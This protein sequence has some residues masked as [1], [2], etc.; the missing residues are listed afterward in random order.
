M[1]VSSRQGKSISKAAGSRSLRGCLDLESSSDQ[2]CRAVE[3]TQSALQRRLWPAVEVTQSALQ[4]RLWPVGWRGLKIWEPTSR[5][6]L[7]PPVGAPFSPAGA[8]SPLVNAPSHSLWTHPRCVPWYCHQVPNP[9]C[10]QELSIYN[11]YPPPNPLQLQWLLSIVLFAHRHG[12]A[13]TQQVN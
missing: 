9:C 3:V 6:Q 13:P 11:M 7:P 5:L 1:M 2:L 8:L 4:K 12:L 10:D